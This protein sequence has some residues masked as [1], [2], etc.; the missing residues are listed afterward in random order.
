MHLIVLKRN[1]DIKREKDI[2]K[3]KDREKERKTFPDD[4]KRKHKEKVVNE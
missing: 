3:H 2:Y 1:R 4:S